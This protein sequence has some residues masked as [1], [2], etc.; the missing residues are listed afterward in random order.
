MR[1]VATY[2]VEALA[3]R[4]YRLYPKLPQD[5]PVFRYLLKMHFYE[6]CLYLKFAHFKA[7]QAILEAFVG[8]KKVYVIDFSMKQGMQCTTLMQALA[9][10]PG[11]PPTFRLTGIGL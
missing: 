1:K 2:F 10:R 8:K 3:R 4:I 9:L 6:T 11:G 5:L 7:N